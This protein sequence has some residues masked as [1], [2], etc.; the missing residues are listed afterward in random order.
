MSLVAAAPA[1]ERLLGH[2]PREATHGSVDPI[3]GAVHVYQD[4][5]YLGVMKG[6]AYSSV[7]PRG[8][9]CTALDADTVQQLPGWNK[10]VDE[11]NRRW[12]DGERDISTN[13]AEY[14]EHQASICVTNNEVDVAVNGDPQCN[15]KSQSIGG[16]I[17]GTNG[18][19]ALSQTEGTSYT[20]ETTTSRQ[21]SVAT[22]VSFEAKFKIGEIFEVGGGVSVTTTV[23][24]SQGSSNSATN[25]QQT[26]QTI[27][28]S[29]RDG[30]TCKLD[31]ETKTCTT[32]GSGQLPFVGTGA[33]W[34]KYKDRD[35]NGHWMHWLRMDAFAPEESDR[36]LYMSFD[37]LVNTETKSS[38]HVV[39]Q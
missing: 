33:V 1:P 36:S 10:L 13:E 25:N 15:T 4:R 20:L 31:F 34:F 17:I 23:Q 27:T 9:D 24:N 5:E 21:V 2:M 37:A 12:G 3:S 11:A 8:S 26:T 38:Y 6:E 28:A 16:D 7:Y 30:Q 39:C 32:K 19:V 18:T 22:D 14:P 35:S 29:Q